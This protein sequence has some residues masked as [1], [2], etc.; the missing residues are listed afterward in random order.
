MSKTLNM[1]Q[2]SPIKLLIRFSLPLMLGNVFQQ[3][4]TVVDTAIVGRG[5]GMTALAALGCVDWLNW[6]MLGLAQ[7]FTQGFSVRVAQK[8]GEK[9]GPGLHLFMGQSSVLM[10]ALIILCAVVGQVCLPLFLHFLRVPPELQPMAELYTRIL[11]AGIPAVFFFN[12]CAAMLRAVGNSKTPLVAMVVAALTNIALDCVA[13]FILDWGVAGAAIATLIAQILSGVICFIRICRTP[14][15]R[16]PAKTMK[17]NRDIMKNL[18]KIGTPSA[19]KN[20]VVA[21]GGMAVTSVVNTFGTAFIAGFTSSN[22]LYGLLEIA[23][24]SYGYAVITYVGQ[25]YG[26]GRIDRIKSGM[27]SAAILA[28][29]TSLVI[30]ALM[31]VFGRDITMLFIS[32]ENPADA[33]QAGEF[34][35]RYLCVMAAC[36]PVL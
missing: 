29:A 5:V 9:D 13:V 22:K 30:A 26:A 16:Y 31:F 33:L 4:Y 10:G 14:Q 7:G 17:P 2:G 21:L 6:M 36:L 12:Y 35:Y 23:A 27:K 24:L 18:L 20:L 25:N 15:L 11:F 8:F 1:T 34:A 3:L 19:A 32:T 28:V